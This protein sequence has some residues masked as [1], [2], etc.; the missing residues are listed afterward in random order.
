VSY[1]NIKVN[2]PQEEA[3]SGVVVPFH[4]QGRSC[5][6]AER[7]TTW[8]VSQEGIGHFAPRIVAVQEGTQMIDLDTFA[9]TVFSDIKR[10]A[11]EQNIPFEYNLK[12]RT[13]KRS[14]LTISVGEN[15]GSAV[16]SYVRPPSSTATN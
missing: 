4:F 5:W 6:E 15:H 11:P 12:A 14:I 10:L 7:A 8:Q 1:V 2:C 3:R 13:Y 16:V 9:K